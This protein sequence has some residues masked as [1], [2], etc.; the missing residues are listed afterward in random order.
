MER[1]CTENRVSKPRFNVTEAK[2]ATKS[3]GTSATTLNKVTSRMCNPAPAVPCLRSQNKCTI[4]PKIKATMATATNPFTINKIRMLPLE[5]LKG[6]R[7]VSSKKVEKPTTVPNITSAIATQ[8]E[9]PRIRFANLMSGRLIMTC[10][11]PAL[12]PKINSAV[13]ILPQDYTS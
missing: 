10:L 1:I 5:G 13:T 4:C 12:L 11:C 8:P 3:A 9:R 7:P 6:V 2:A